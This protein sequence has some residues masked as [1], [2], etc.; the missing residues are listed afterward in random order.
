MGLDNLTNGLSTTNKVALGIGAVGLVAGAGLGAVALA[1]KRKSRKSKR[2]KGRNVRKRSNR[3]KR[4]RKTPHTA[5]KGKDRSHKRIRYT[6][7]GQPYVIMSSGKARFIKK[8]SAKRS[9][10]LKGGRY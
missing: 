2:R 6:K 3:N 4:V 1:R 10:K 8:S 5:G 9:H 7:T